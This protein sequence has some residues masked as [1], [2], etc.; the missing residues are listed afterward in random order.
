MA[1]TT[2]SA[3]ISKKNEKEV[4]AINQMELILCLTL[5]LSLLVF[6]FGL[7]RALVGFTNFEHSHAGQTTLMAP[8]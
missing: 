5:S 7:E 6:A 2:S 4:V 1:S 8:D 3:T